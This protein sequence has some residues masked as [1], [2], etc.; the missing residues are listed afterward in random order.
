MHRGCSGLHPG[1]TGRRPLTPLPSPSRYTRPSFALTSC[2]LEALETQGIVA[3]PG[4]AWSTD[5]PYRETHQEVDQYGAEGA[6]GAG[7]EAVGLFAAAAL[8]RR[9]GSR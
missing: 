3:R 6:L 4:P 7:M 9:T 5:V 1:A 8:N 2:L